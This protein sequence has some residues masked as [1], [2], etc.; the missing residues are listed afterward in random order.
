MR[1]AFIGLGWLVAVLA[2]YAALT[3]IEI[4]WNLLDW[5]PR[6]DLPSFGILGT[7]AALEVGIWF[8]ASSTRGKFVRTGS[9]VL[10]IGLLGIGVYVICPE[11]VT[12][13]WLARS[14]SSPWWYRAGRLLLLGFP[15]CLWL[16][17][18]YRRPPV[19]A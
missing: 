7:I 15:C 4:Y 3:S 18:F 17:T 10:V 13:G 16:V 12:Q 8:L 11:P 5:H 1:A 2:L 6:F 14:T 9:A 19:S